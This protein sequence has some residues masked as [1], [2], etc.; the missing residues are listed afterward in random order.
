MIN[1][2][3][4][5]EWTAVQD[6]FSRVLDLD[7]AGGAVS[8]VHDGE[9]VV[10]LWGGVDPLSGAL[11]E[12]DS[13]A[14][15]FSTSKGVLALL[16]AIEVERGALERAEPVARYWPEFAAAGKD[17]ITVHDVMTH[18]SGLPVLPM[19]DA[20]SLLDAG[21]LAARLAG[22]APAYPPRSA[23]IYHV[24]SYGTIL[25]EVL[26]RV[27]GQDIASLVQTRIAEPLGDDGQGSPGGSLWF[28]LPPSQDSRYRPSLMGP[29][30]H[31]APPATE[32]PACWSA[33]RANSQITPLFE[34]MDGVIGSEAMNGVDF[35]RAQLGG[36][37][38]VADARTLARMYGACT[39][40]V[41]GVRLLSSRTVREVSSDQLR[42]ISEPRCAPDAVLTSRW[43]LGFEISHQAN[44]MLGEGSFGHAG[45]GGRL[46]FAHEGH[47]LG[48][49]FIGQRMLFPEPGKDERWQLLLDAVRDVL[50]G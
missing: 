3:T 29:V 31:P 41:Q 34:R 36:G 38:L 44:P 35:R 5:S 17:D 7:A 20:A 28:G 22:E 15:T 2:Y 47:R 14:L 21:G 8:V 6:A 42:G 23:R 50:Y 24:L 39:S 26:R 30:E 13:V 37:G 43:G 16:A 4:T 32:N 33:Y 25:G 19:T 48:F 1:G 9:T 45:M 11:W 46:S 18:V 40:E 49:A 12:S 10:D 27:T